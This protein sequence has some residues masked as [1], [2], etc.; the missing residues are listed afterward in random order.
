MGSITP[1]K[2]F[3]LLMTIFTCLMLV[4]F[5]LF[6]QADAK[7]KSNSSS[8]CAHCHVMEAEYEAWTHSGAHR[9]KG[10]HYDGFFPV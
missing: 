5:A 7:E 8:F 2:S 3:L 6:A 4:P 1:K 10:W 9:R